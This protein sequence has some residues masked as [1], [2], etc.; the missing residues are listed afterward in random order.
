MFSYSSLIPLIK[1]HTFSPFFNTSFLKIYS[2]SKFRIDKFIFSLFIDNA[3]RYYLNSKKA[4]SE[5]KR[6]VV[7][8][9]GRKINVIF[10]ADLLIKG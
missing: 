5:G 6:K 3:T 4:G 10:K 9:Q 7:I 2:K 1:M 8:F